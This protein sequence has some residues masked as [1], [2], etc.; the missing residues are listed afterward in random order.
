MDRLHAMAVLVQVAEQRSFA[1]AARRLNLSPPAVTR[2]V[3]WLE[4]RVGARLLTR[5]TRTVRLT[6]A[7]ERFCEDCRRIL[8]DLAEA[9]GA[10]AGAHA[11]LKGQ[12]S[13][14]ASTLFGRL[15][16]LPIVMRFLDD[17]PGVAVRSLFVDR[18]V[19][20]VEEGIDVAVRIGELPSSSLQARRVGSVRRVV[21]AAPAYLARAGL[22]QALADLSDHSIV[23]TTASQSATAWR[24]FGAGVA[25]DVPIAPRLITSSNDAAI[26][27]A[28]AGWGLTRLLS[29]QVA[30]ELAAGRLKI[31]LA[32]Y[33]PPPLPIHVV[34]AEGRRMPARLRAFVDFAADQLR[35]NPLIN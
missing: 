25:T 18:V 8:S 14:T 20:L 26:D 5:T 7:G 2:A 30:P 22:P 35:S 9:E 33:E 4:D 10:A 31:V 34:H 28:V 11:E 32:E 12:L 29:Y 1:A 3:G 27:A 19:N 24:F 23:A 13:L 16:V 17:H 21:C 15:F 6:E